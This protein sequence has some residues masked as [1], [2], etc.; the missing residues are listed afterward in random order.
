MDNVQCIGNENRL[1]DCYFDGWG[2]HAHQTTCKSMF[3]SCKNE[4]YDLRLY[5]RQNDDSGLLEVYYSG[6]W[7]FVCDSDWS[8]HNSHV[9]C[10]Q[11]GFGSAESS[12]ILSSPPVGGLV[13]MDGVN[14]TGA[15]S[16]L[17]DCPFKGWGYARARCN[18]SNYVGVVCSNHGNSEMNV[19]LVGSDS[20]TRGLVQVQYSGRWGYVCGHYWGDFEA[21]VSY[22]I[23]L[24]FIC[25]FICLFIIFYKSVVYF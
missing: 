21:K 2:N 11:L 25:L 1:Q 4:N 7:G 24:L 19:R 10:K 3:V 9:A 16:R 12:Y 23:C 17:V 22:Y 8:L 13:L 18:G 14:C 6:G 20:E 15:E 5:N